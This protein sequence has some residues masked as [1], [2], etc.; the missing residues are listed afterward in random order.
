MTDKP[1]R[2]SEY[3]YEHVELV[4][5]TLLYVATRIE[6]SK[7]ESCKE[8]WRIQVEQCESASVRQE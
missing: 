5:S 1:Q 3:T 7:S 8:S 2:A 6:S 4:R